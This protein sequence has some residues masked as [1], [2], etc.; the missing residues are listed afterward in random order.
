MKQFISPLF[1]DQVIGHIS[2]LQNTWGRSIR[3]NYKDWFPRMCEYG[4]TEG[5]DFI[6]IL[7]ESTGGCPGMD[8]RPTI[9][10]A[11]EH[12]GTELLR[13]RLLTTSF[14]NPGSRLI[15]RICLH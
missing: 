11:E 13:Y 15:W 5:R 14:L 10:M 6:S 8:H 9:E 4:F 2:S 7:R 1:D 3:T 12:M